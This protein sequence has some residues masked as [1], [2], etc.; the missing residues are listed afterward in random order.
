MNDFVPPPIADLM[1]LRGKTAV[2]TGAAV[3]MGAATAR[4]FAEAEAA[5]HLLDIDQ[6]NLLAL[7]T[8]LRDAGATVDSTVLD[9]AKKE[10]IDAFWEKVDDTP[11]D[12]LV[13]NAGIFPFRGFLETDE[14]FVREV[15]DVNFMAV[16]WM[17]QHFVRRRLRDKEAGTIVNIGSIEASLPFM[18]GL[19][20]YA[21]GKV[22]VIALTRALAHDY[23]KKGIRANVVLPGG[24]R[25]QGTKKVIQG[26]W[27]DW[28]LLRD[29]VKYLG[30][31]PLGRMGQADE[32]ARI[33]LMLASDMSS[34]MT[35]AVIAVDGG[36][37]SA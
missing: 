33:N 6:K 3:G 14:A 19:A 26:I 5:L 15:M 23:G 30:R 35:G 31:S 4:R 8:E 29:G 22:A 27:K 20:H 2:I 10:D 7:Q 9:L 21:T 25:T 1:S 36:F 12:V 28:T 13:N 11:I 34:Y 17:C 24:I 18:E 16:Y 32:V 37:L